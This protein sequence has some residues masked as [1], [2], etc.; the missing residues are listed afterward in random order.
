MGSSLRRREGAV[1][2]RSVVSGGVRLEQHA[3]LRDLHHIAGE[4]HLDL[5][6]AQAVV[7]K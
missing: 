5:L 6:A 1:F 2:L 4:P 3:A 7:T